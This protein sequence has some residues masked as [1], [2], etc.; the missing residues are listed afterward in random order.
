M[1]TL[2]IKLFHTL[3]KGKEQLGRDALSRV[4]QFIESQ[5]T[6]NAAFKNK[7]GQEDIYYTVFGLM[8]SYVLGIEIDRKK[9]AAYLKRLD[10]DSMD[11]IH[12]AAYMRCLM[13]MRL[14][15]DGKIGFLLKSLSRTKIRELDGFTGLPHNDL[16]SPYTRFIWL[17]LLEDT[18]QPVAN[19]EAI[20]QSLDL[21]KV[22]GG[23]YANIQGNSAA[24]TNAT[25]AALSVVGQLTGYKDCENI[26]YLQDIQE[27]SGG[28]SA[29]KQAPV[30]DL[31][32]TATS[33]FTL[34]CYGVQ[35]HI[36][37]HDFIEAHWLDSGGFAATLLEENSDVE[38]T[39]YG[40]LALGASRWKSE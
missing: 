27:E 38:Y 35:P 34:S 30:P 4:R 8:V 11:L 28:F 20:L 3:Q 39:F 13:I 18:G 15:Q 24:T 36:P 25:V 23:G 9:T 5:R 17:S 22:P 32:S 16:Q 33:L 2:S 1:D 29:T 12:Y 21:Y 19:K 14:V 6:D 7:S 10:S 26:R 37:P 40:L 31:L